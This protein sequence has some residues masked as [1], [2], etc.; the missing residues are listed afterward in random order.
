[1]KIAS[2]KLFA[3][4]IWVVMMILQMRYKF[5][6]SDAWVDGFSLVTALYI[7]GQAAVDA[8]QKKEK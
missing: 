8:L 6:I 1:M 7:G 2:R 4:M 5:T 3:F